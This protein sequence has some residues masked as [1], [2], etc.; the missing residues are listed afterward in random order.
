MANSG[1]AQLHVKRESSGLV[2][3]AFGQTARGQK[4]RRATIPLTSDDTRVD[5]FKGE[6]ATEIAKLFG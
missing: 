3:V 6:L 2:L 5:S 1:I 4:F